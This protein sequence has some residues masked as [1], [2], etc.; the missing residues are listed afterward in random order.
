MP[1][2]R[3]AA[4]DTA[5]RASKRG[6]PA[7][8][9]PQSI[10][11]DDDYVS[12]E[13]DEEGDLIQLDAE[14]KQKAKRE[15]AAIKRLAD[16][17]QFSKLSK[18][19]QH[20][21]LF[22]NKD[23]HRM[24]LKKDHEN[25]PLWLDARV[26]DGSSKGPKITLEYF[27]PNAAKAT[28][29]LTTI[30]EPVSRP[31]H[32]HEWRINEHSLYAALSVG[33]KGDDI[34]NALDK[35]AKTGVPQE[36]K[37][38]VHR[39]TLTYGKVRLVLREN[40]FW[41]ESEDDEVIHRLLADPT[42]ASC[43]AAGAEVETGVVQTRGTVIQGTAQA[44]GLTQTAAQ[45]PEIPRDDPAAEQERMIAALRDED[46]DE[47]TF[48]KT[49]SFEITQGHREQVA[50]RCLDMGLPAVSEYD[51]AN[52]RINPSLLIDLKPQ[53]Q[54]RPYQEKALS[55]MF[56]NGRGKSGIIVLPCGAG[57]T[58]V[59][60]TAGCHIKKSIVV[61]CTS[62]M[63][64]TQWAGEFKK[65]SDVREEDVASF[66]STSKTKFKGEAGVLVSTYSMMCMD[67][68][69]NKAAHD[70]KEMLR[71][72]RSKEWGLMI[73]DEVHVVPAQTFRKVTDGVRAHC[74]LGLTATLLREDDKI[75]DLNYLIGPKLYEAN[76]MELANQGHIARVQCAEVWC[77]MSMEFYKEYQ[78]AS[79]RK[80]LLFYACN[81]VK[82]QV[83]QFLINYHESR[84]DKIIV[85]SD[86]IFALEHYAKT[87]MKAYI[88]GGTSERERQEV[89]DNFQHND[90]V[91]TV[92]LSKIGDTSLDLPEA[93][94]LIQI[95]SHYGSRRQ[96]AQ[97]LGRIL[98]AKRRNDEGFNAYFY[99]L[100]SK[101]TTEMAYSAK[102]Q[103]FLVDQGYSFKTIT[104]LKGM[105]ELPGLL[106]RD[107]RERMELLSDVMLQS[108]DAAKEES[109]KGNLWSDMSTNQKKSL[110]RS[111]GVRRTA[112][113]LA[114]MGGGGIMAP[115]Y[116]ERARGAKNEEKSAFFEKEKR[117][118]I[119]LEKKR[120]QEAA[121]AE[122]QASRGR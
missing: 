80:Q 92:F 107:P 42:I 105:Q 40:R 15:T 75:T 110:G 77:P 10:G 19:F 9:T 47:D 54:I 71:W 1:V 25:R 7:P 106:Y 85:F 122:V 114:D 102:R 56:G 49:H 88:H 113:S 28:D 55:K 112:A 83:C 13:Y 79:A 103:A 38:F 70:T 116:T 3:K 96:E 11:S 24:P 87:M 23:F 41:V 69:N 90:M 57:K 91:N 32:F 117:R 66:S 86:N 16:H 46:D 121:E 12:D 73:L 27:A 51:F 39:N 78:K 53:T 104:H 14:E 29:L 34:I 93:T 82:F 21:T 5:G 8:S 48:R 74:K 84:G 109:I 60:I 100:V 72:V 98:R 36:I 35:F 63:S 43:K 50:Q 65:W 115:L 37:E 26:A 22:K 30:A 95:S 99:S 119:N 108:E 61:L 111:A 81:P 6:T 62:G 52:D 20:S 67:P 2:K 18:N 76:W 45:G 31:A 58:L 97:R 94:V 17:T 33:L 59:G 4:D 120:R 101:D 44:K 118:R 64:V 68:D 89:L